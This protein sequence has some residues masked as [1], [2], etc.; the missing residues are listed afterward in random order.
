MVGEVLGERYKILSKLGSGGMAE[1]YKAHCQIL[2][3]TVAIKVLR[4][5]FASNEEFVERFRREAQAAAGLSHPN[6]VSIYDVGKDEERYYIVMEY[7]RG[8]SLKEAIRRSGHLPPQRAARIAWQILAAL[9]HAHENGIV[10]RDIKPHN[11]MVTSDER[12][13][14][15]DFGIARA[16][17]ASTLTDT[18]TIIGTVNYFSPEQAR[19]EAVEAQSDIYSSGVVLYEM[20]TGTVPFR[21]ESPI[22]IALQH[23][24]TSVTP[25]TELNATI[26]GGLERI[27]L[28]A[29]EKN[30]SRRYQDARHMMRALEPYAFPGNDYDTINDDI[31]MDGDTT[32]TDLT[33]QVLSSPSDPGADMEETQV[34]RKP[35]NSNRRRTVFVTLFLVLAL[36]ALAAGI[37]FML[38]EWLYVE[39]VRVPDFTGKTLEE[40]EILAGKAHVRLDSP[41]KRYDETIPANR[42]VSQRPAAYERVKM[43]SKVT[44]VVSLG[45]EIVEMPDLLGMDLREALLELE[46][47]ELEPG[48]QSRDYSDEVEANKVASQSPAAGV[49]VEKGSMVEIVLSDGPEPLLVTIQDFRGMNMAQA[50]SLLTVSGLVKG[51]V[52]EEVREGAEPGII[53]SQWPEPGQLVT[54]GSA[55]DFVVGKGQ[56]TSSLLDA[57]TPISSLV[58]I[59][60]PPGTDLQ[61]VKI[62]INDYYGERDYYVGMHTPGERIE[63]QINAWGRKMRIRVYIGGVLYRDESVPKG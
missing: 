40:A 50:E 24:E 13:K 62:R 27:V 18:G 25:P 26:P 49:Q 39:E 16:L 44:L 54:L 19:G 5:Q 36:L 14:V 38:P 60:V 45:K 46:R 15:T 35:K 4:P 56:D 48:A 51:R 21:G 17:S 23:L 11:V 47:L 34:R 43:N 58:T 53:V 57:I 52:T 59:V 32:L 30:P 31:H 55:V 20:L 61:E 63:K 29:L 2:N 37:I 22:S 6:I 41:D 9:Q 28:K 7:V 33:A 10:H 8:T 12:V 1:V 3:R 42:V